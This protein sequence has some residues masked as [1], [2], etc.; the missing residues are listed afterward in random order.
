M[1]WLPPKPPALG[2]IIVYFQRVIGSFLLYK[3]VG[4]I[5]AIPKQ[6]KYAK[7]DSKRLISG[8]LNR[9]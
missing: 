9:S 7:E 5:F 6:C 3:K 4:I 8:K 2:D 1:N